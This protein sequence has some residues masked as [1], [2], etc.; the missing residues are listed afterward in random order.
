MDTREVK[1]VERIKKKQLYISMTFNYP[2]DKI[3]NDI[4]INNFRN[5]DKIFICFIRL[6]PTL[7]TSKLANHSLN[8]YFLNIKR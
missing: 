8:I 5:N 3:N 4:T 7:N 1:V 6:F 2:L